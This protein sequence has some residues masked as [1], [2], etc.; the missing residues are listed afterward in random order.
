MQLSF[1]LITLT[2]LLCITNR[3][4]FTFFFNSIK[5]SLSFNLI[6]T[7]LLTFLADS[8]KNAKSSSNLVSERTA[9]N[10]NNLKLIIN[11]YKLESFINDYAPETESEE[12]QKH[13]ILKEIRQ[14]RNKKTNEVKKHIQF[15]K[16]AK[17]SAIRDT[18]VK[19]IEKFLELMEAEY[20]KLNPVETTTKMPQVSDSVQINSEQNLSILSPQ[21]RSSK[22]T[23]LKAA[24]IRR[25][26]IVNRPQDQQVF[27]QFVT[28][29]PLFNLPNQEPVVYKLQFTSNDMID[30]KLS[31]ELS[32]QQTT[33]SVYEL[34]DRNAKSLFSKNNLDNIPNLSAIKGVEN[35]RNQSMNDTIDLDLIPDCISNKTLAN[36]QPVPKL[37]NKK[38]EE[39]RKRISSGEINSDHSKLLSILS[40][41]KSSL[42]ISTASNNETL[43]N[44]KNNENLEINNTVSTSPEE[45][46]TLL[47]KIAIKSRV[48]KGKSSNEISD[49]SSINLAK[50]AVYKQ[51]NELKSQTNNRVMI[52]ETLGEM[53]S[54]RGVF[55][56]IEP[57]DFHDFVNKNFD[58]ILL[59]ER[60]KH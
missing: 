29:N 6:M 18:Q 5:F 28:S 43:S 51:L 23:Q 7:F 44:E 36:S 47:D 4:D 38:Q 42:G 52:S 3:G 39:L 45:K 50:E 26:F 35:H 1:F 32:N 15:L 41:E 31:G 20:A 53:Q 49:K 8:D 25:D 56:K 54:K 40:E 60:K 24:E 57:G 11:S 46:G 13:R 9:K 48:S 34:N 16:T 10:A 2:I 19:H 17:P 27:Y 21:N 33:K 59:D 58:Y 22:I 14:I 12:E 30:D 37:T 55:D